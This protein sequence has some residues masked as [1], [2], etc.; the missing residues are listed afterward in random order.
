VA[1]ESLSPE[2]VLSMTRKELSEINQR[3]G[4]QR[5]GFR[6]DFTQ[7]LVEHVAKAGFS[8]TLGARPLQRTIESMVMAPLSRWM[9]D[10]QQVGTNAYSPS[11]CRILLDWIDDLV[12]INASPLPD[13]LV[14]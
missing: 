12:F 2:T 10:R 6:L 1:F 9:I 11:D 7:E 13:R 14:Q 5:Q 3:E 4:V 8:P